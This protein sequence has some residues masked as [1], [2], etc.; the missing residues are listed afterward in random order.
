MTALRNFPDAPMARR[1]ARNIEWKLPP[2]TVKVWNALQRYGRMRGAW[3]LE[4]LADR[5]AL[6]DPL[7]ARR[8]RAAAAEMRQGT[9]DPSTPS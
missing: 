9:H 6:G 2:W 4:V 3:E 5:R 7:L 1:R 8:L